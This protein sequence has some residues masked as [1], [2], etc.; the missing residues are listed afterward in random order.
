M[1]KWL[2]ICCNTF[3]VVFH[4]DP[5]GYFEYHFEYSGN[6]CEVIFVHLCFFLSLLGVTLN[7]LSITSAQLSPECLPNASRMPPRCLP[8]GPLVNAFFSMILLQW[9]LLNDLFLWLLLQWLLLHASWSSICLLW[10]LKL[11]YKQNSVWG[12]VLG[13]LEF[14]VQSFRWPLRAQPW[15]TLMPVCPFL[16]WTDDSPTTG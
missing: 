5:W 13:S 10:F 8:D 6:P 1:T 9:F 16:P 2:R 11:V 3:P 7:H 15:G 12:L 14:G 4:L